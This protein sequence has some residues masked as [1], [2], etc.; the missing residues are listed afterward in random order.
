MTTR[1][2]SAYLFFSQ[3]IGN[4]YYYTSF[5]ANTDLAIATFN[6]ITAIYGIS[7]L[8]L[9]QHDIFSYCLFPNAGTIDILAFKLLISFYPFFLVF[10]YFILRHYCICK[11]QCFQKWRLSSK[12]ITHGISTFL[13]LC[14]AKINILAFAILK[15]AE[16]SYINGEI[17]GRVV[18]L[19]GD[20]K[21]FE[22][23]LY[24][25]YAIGSLLMLVIIIAIPI[26]ILM[27]HPIII[28]I[29]I[30]FECGESY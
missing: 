8:E 3:I 14:F 1:L 28:N 11:H 29:A 20:F 10:I 7:N 27:F 23:P 2:I 26:M 24:N 30:C 18:H 16:L 4:H 22:E 21:Y 9:F 12:S 15:Y 17:Y 13:V 5:K 6:I 25:V 19:Q